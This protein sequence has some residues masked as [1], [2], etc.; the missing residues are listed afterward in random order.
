MLE[1]KLL[2]LEFINFKATQYKLIYIFL[3]KPISFCIDSAVHKHLLSGSTNKTRTSH[4]Q[5]LP[6][7]GWQEDAIFLLCL[8]RRLSTLYLKY[9]KLK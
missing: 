4:L 3:T 2:A 8:K 6:G 9:Q 1:L 5:S 7:G